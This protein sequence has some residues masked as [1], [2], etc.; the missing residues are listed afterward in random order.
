MGAHEYP[1]VLGDANFDGTITPKE[2]RV[3]AVTVGDVVFIINYLFRSGPASCPY[4]SADTNCDGEVN[5]S[6]I[7]CLI[8]YL[9]RGGDLPC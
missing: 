8:N 6:D 7:V 4:H 5:A 9:F 3:G 2:P 1:Y